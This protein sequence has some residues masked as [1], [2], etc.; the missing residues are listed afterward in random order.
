[1]FVS[2]GSHVQKATNHNEQFFALG[3]D[4]A[5][6]TLTNITISNEDALTGSHTNSYP[7]LIGLTVNSTPAVPEPAPIALLGLGLIPVGGL[8]LRARRRQTA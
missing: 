4:F 6:Q 3:S 8:M 5:G 7:L 2:G 1:M